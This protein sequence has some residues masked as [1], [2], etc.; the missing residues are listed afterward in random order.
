MVSAFVYAG[1]VGWARMYQGVHY[2]SDV[3]AGIVVGSGTALLVN[4]A[5]HKLE[6]KKKEKEVVVY[7]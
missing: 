2:P 7:L 5:K 1:S 4:W 6:K 3:L